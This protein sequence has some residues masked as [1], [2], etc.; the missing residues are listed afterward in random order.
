MI[1]IY[2][3]C[4]KGKTTAALGL[5]LRAAGAGLKVY[6][7]Q[8]SKGRICSEHLALKKFKNVKIEQF[9]SCAFV[10]EITPKDIESAKEG[11]EAAKK[12]IKSGKFEVIILDEINV[13][14]KLKLLRLKEAIELL[15]CARIGQELILTGRDA[16][17]ELINLADLVS[18]I[19]EVKHYFKKGVK[20]RIGIEF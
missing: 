6:I 1:Q 18:E 16:H 8:F 3:G 12:A 17:P 4:G 9:G 13:A 14:L 10:R 5:A 11:L 2:T 20:A 15:K 19:M 7:C